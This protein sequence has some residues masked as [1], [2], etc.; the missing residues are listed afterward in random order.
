MSSLHPYIKVGVTLPVYQANSPFFPVLSILHK[1]P[2]NTTGLFCLTGLRSSSYA[3]SAPQTPQPLTRAPLLAGFYKAAELISGGKL[4]KQI[5]GSNVKSNSQPSMLS[6]F[7]IR[8]QGTR[9]RKKI[10]R[11]PYQHFD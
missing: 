5:P 3:P 4:N 8:W 2:S 10:E 7:L 9:F 6:A 1:S 11:A